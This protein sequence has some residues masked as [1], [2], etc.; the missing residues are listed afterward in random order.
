MFKIIIFELICI[1]IIIIVNIIIYK[2]G[3]KFIYDSSDPSLCVFIM[4]VI[5]FISIFIMYMIPKYIISANPDLFLKEN[6][7]KPYINTYDNAMV[8]F[9]ENP[10]TGI[11]YI[12]DDGY[13]YVIDTDNTYRKIEKY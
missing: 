1:F 11:K 2:L 8:P 13:I 4:L 9:I 5:T 3:N 10:K 12:F 6:Q 7:T